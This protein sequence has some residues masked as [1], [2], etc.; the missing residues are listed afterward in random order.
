MVDAGGGSQELVLLIGFKNRR[1]DGLG[2]IQ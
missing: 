1:N 2:M